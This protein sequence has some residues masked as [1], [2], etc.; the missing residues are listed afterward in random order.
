MRLNLTAKHRRLS[1]QAPQPPIHAQAVTCKVILYKSQ[2][3]QNLD[4]PLRICW[5]FLSLPVLPSH[6]QGHEA[7]GEADEC[8]AAQGSGSWSS[9]WE[10]VL[11]A[12]KVVGI[13]LKAFCRLTVLELLAPEFQALQRSLLAGGF[14]YTLPVTSGNNAGDVFAPRNQKLT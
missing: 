3:G 12:G 6:R 7:L 14:C 10:Q 9:C 13:D 2:K 8:Q 1:T 4:P 11:M 5:P